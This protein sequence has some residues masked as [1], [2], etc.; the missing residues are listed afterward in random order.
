[1]FE[2]PSIMALIAQHLES[3]PADPATINPEVP[4]A[5]ARAILRA[6]AR[7]PED[8]WQSAGELLRALESV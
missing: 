7:R 5:L 6:L 8:R 2:A 4:P 1:V 3:E